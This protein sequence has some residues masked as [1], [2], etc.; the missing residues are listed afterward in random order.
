MI[1]V[2][3]MGQQTQGYNV[4]GPCAG[5]WYE[6]YKGIYWYKKA[7][8]A[9]RNARRSRHTKTKEPMIE[10]QKRKAVKRKGRRERGS[11]TSGCGDGSSNYSAQFLFILQ[12]LLFLAQLYSPFAGL[13]RHGLVLPPTIHVLLTWPGVVAA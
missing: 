10:E 9:V 3:A 6:Y 12:H 7:T 13:W 4:C 11:K 1:K 5:T 2:M 8:R